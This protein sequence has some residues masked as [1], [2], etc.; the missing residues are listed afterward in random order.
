MRKSPTYKRYVNECDSLQIQC[1]HLSETELPP[2]YLEIAMD[3]LTAERNLV[4]PFE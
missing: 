4:K 1:M 3:T 2:A